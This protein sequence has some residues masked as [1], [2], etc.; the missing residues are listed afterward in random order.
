MKKIQFCESSQ[1]QVHIFTR[2][3]PRCIRSLTKQDSSQSTLGFKKPE[4]FR[5]YLE[6]DNYTPSLKQRHLYQTLFPREEQSRDR[7]SETIIAIALAPQH[8]DPSRS[9]KGALGLKCIPRIKQKKRWVLLTNGY[10]R[11]TDLRDRSEGFQGEAG[12]A[13]DKYKQKGEREKKLLQE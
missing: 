13:R 10:T 3:A 4:A 5:R 11:H 9:E 6:S 2:S 1:T 12:T 8:G 7:H